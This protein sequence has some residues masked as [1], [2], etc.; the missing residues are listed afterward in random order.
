MRKTNKQNLV[1]D[2]VINSIYTETMSGN[3]ASPHMA[4]HIK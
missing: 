1:S 3:V 2:G 4:L